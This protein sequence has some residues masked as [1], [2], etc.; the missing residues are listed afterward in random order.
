MWT[1][2]G[3]REME[4]QGVLFAVADDSLN[5]YEHNTLLENE[6]GRGFRN[7]SYHRGV[8]TDK[9]GRGV[10]GFDMDHDGDVDLYVAN[11]RRRGTLYRNDI[12]ELKD[13][14]WL[15]IKLVGV[16]S[17]RDAVGA[18]LT[19]EAGGVK[20]I[21]DV[22]IGEAYLSGSTLVQHFG[23]AEVSSVDSLTVRWPSGLV[24]SFENVPINARL[25]IVEGEN[26]LAILSRAQDEGERDADEGEGPSDVNAPNA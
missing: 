4:K 21:R 3:R 16:K 19:L 13:R 18:R 5:G 2:V 10:V 24:Q 17:N 6:G 20:Q 22:R 14:N 8:D 1:N 25:Q 15:Q 26:E 11:Y 7:V 23:L 9:D 12:S